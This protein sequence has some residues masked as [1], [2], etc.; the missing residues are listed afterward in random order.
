M[1]ED[2]SISK[3]P[4]AANW[5]SKLHNPPTFFLDRSLGRHKV[6]AALRKAGAQVVIH[7]DRFNQ[8]AADEVWLRAAGENRW[9]VFTKDKNIRF[10]L[11]EKETLVEYGV[12][13]FVLTAKALN[14]EEMGAI[15]V[16]ALSKIVKVLENN[17]GPFVATI[18][19]S[20]SIRIVW[21]SQG[22]SKD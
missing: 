7:D 2:D 17:A 13:A 8:D 21:P 6:A 14:A 10:H 1:A 5:L 22:A 9:V 11:R 20:G 15:F 12:R 16:G 19:A 3:K 4:S 18:S